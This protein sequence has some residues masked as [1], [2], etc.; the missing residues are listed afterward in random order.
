MWWI[1]RFGFNG[2]SGS[3][4]SQ[5]EIPQEIMRKSGRAEVPTIV[6]DNPP[7]HG[8]S[9]AAGIFSSWGGLGPPR[10]LLFVLK[11]GEVSRAHPTQTGR[12]HHGTERM[13]RV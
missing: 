5:L 4:L 13:R 12:Q 3:S 1:R 11:I 7:A 2:R 6:L 9:T 8:P 10:K